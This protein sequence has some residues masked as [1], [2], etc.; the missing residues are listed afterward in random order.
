MKWIIDSFAALL[1]PVVSMPQESVSKLFRLEANAERGDLALPCFP[2]AKSMKMKPEAVAQA[3]AEQLS[4]CDEVKLAEAVGPFLNI[5]L[6]L[7]TIADHVLATCLKNPDSFGHN[8][9]GQGKTVVLDFSS[10]NI[11]KPIAFHHIRSTV[12]GNALANLHEACGWKTVRIN[13]LGD[14]GTTQGKL[15][16]AFRRF[17][18][19][20]RLEASPIEHLLEIYVRFHQEAETQPELHDEAKRLFKELEDGDTSC[21]ALWMRFRDLSIREFKRIYDRMGIDFDH[22]DGESLYRDRLDATIEEVTQKAG[23]KLDQGALIVDLSDKKL[24]P[25]LLRKDDGATLYATRDIAAALD[26]FERFRFDRALYVVASQQTVYFQQLFEVLRRMGLDFASRCEHVPFGMLQLADKTMSTRKGQ[27]IFLEDVLDK[28]AT[29]SREAIAE[30]NPN[31][32]NAEQVAEQVG[33]GAIIFGDLVAH[34]KND[35]TFEWSRILDFKGK[36]G[37]YVQYTHA[38]C[39]SMLRKG[40]MDTGKI[41]TSL[42]TRQEEKEVL[43]AVGQ[44]PEIVEKATEGFDPSLLANH[45]VNLCQSFNSLFSMGADYRFLDERPEIRA[46]RLAL[47]SIVAATLKNGLGLLGL[48]APEEM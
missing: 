8:E 3:L 46:T 25:C 36:T 26:R 13:Y 30:K 32:E 14:W 28:S 16:S 41:D 40:E 23:A 34:R 9:S 2:F 17:G 47:V 45:L 11:A 33:I 38:R 6:R 35:V 18:D 1:S 48:A 29:L 19:A 20:Q 21:E 31:L 43:K 42:F 22:Y 10:P 15:I 39:R 7:S 12:I 37:V 24:P 5:R 27:V 44:F 4:R